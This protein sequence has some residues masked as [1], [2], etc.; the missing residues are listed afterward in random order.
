MRKVTPTNVSIKGWAVYPYKLGPL[1]GSSKA[2]GTGHF[3]I[4]G[5]KAFARTMRVHVY[6]GKQP[7]LSRNI[8]KN[9]HIWDGVLNNIQNS[10]LRTSKNI[11]KYTKHH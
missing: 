1:G 2:L 10:G 3:S 4:A 11:N 5:S 9:N 6:K 7:N 8:G